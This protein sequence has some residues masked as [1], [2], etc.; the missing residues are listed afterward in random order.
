MSGS[1]N[2]KTLRRTI[3]LMAVGLGAAFPALAL[4]QSQAV[5]NG[6]SG[7]VLDL[8]EDVGSENGA[9]IQQWE[10]RATPNQH[11]QFL[12]VSFDP[13][14]GHIYAIQSSLSGKVMTV[15]QSQLANDGANVFQFDYLGSVGQ[16]WYLVPAGGGWYKIYNFGSGKAL[17]VVMNDI[18]LNGANVQQ[19]S[20]LG[21]AAFNQFWFM[22]P[23]P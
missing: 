8:Q 22:S 5:Q 18:Q 12:W 1:L 6:Q 4:A 11:W 9:N 15:D 23:V 14:V 21:S 13:R 10:Y 7:R 19:W 16:L 20:D 3:L 17:D 2:A